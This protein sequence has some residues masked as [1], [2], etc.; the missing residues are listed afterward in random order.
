MEISKKNIFD[1]KYTSLLAKQSEKKKWTS[2]VKTFIHE[3]KLISTAIIV[4]WMCVMMNLFLIYN[5]FRIL[6][7]V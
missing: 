2:S 3:H 5:F 1:V 7:Q 4:F 6:Q